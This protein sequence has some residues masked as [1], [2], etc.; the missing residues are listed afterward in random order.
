MKKGVMI[1]LLVGLLVIS[2]CKESNSYTGKTIAE[3]PQ[4]GQLQVVINSVEKSKDISFY[5]A[6]A[7][8]EK[9]YTYLILDVTVKNSG[10]ITFDFNPFLTKITDE[11]GYS[12]EYD[13]SSYELSPYFDSVGIQSGRSASGKLSYAVPENSRGLKFI[14][15]SYS[16]NII[17]EVKLPA[18]TA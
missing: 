5:S 15:E 7:E 12:Y 6:E 18:Q 10:Q 11:N 9:G 2:G 3:E 17:A 8:A 16:R 1:A 14:I 13:V 4:I